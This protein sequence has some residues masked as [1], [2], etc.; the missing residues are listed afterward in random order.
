MSDEAIAY[1]SG[2]LLLTHNHMRESAPNKLEAES[3]RSPVNDILSVQTREHIHTTLQKYASNVG[4]WITIRH[5]WLMMQI[6]EATF[7]DIWKEVV[8][9]WR[10]E[11]PTFG[12]LRHFLRGYFEVSESTS[13][14]PF[15]IKILALELERVKDGM[16]ERFQHLFFECVQII[17][18]LQ[19]EDALWDVTPLHNAVIQGRDVFSPL[20]IQ[21]VVTNTSSS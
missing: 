17:P 16:P 8:V 21:N 11:R 10:L 7:D 3:E 6:R 18:L 1:V 9:A 19:T 4:N 15:A 14:P 20:N 5:R 13:I 2:Y 12:H